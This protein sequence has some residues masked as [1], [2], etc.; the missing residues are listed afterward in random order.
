VYQH[1]S[2]HSAENGAGCS[3]RNYGLSRVKAIGPM[4]GSP[5]VLDGGWTAE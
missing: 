1:K 4:T 5:L 2:M 3:E